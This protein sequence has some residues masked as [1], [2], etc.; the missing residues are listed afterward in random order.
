M[1]VKMIDNPTAITL[2]RLLILSLDEAELRKWTSTLS[3]MTKPIKSPEI[4]PIL[5][6][7]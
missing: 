2:K 1:K 5:I 4:C 6:I 3:V 7:L